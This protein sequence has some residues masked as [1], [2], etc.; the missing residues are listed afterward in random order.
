MALV[1]LQLGQCGNQVGQE[2]LELV[3]QDGRSDRSRSRADTYRAVSLERFFRQEA[4][5]NVPVARAVLVDMEPKVI[6]RTLSKAMKSGQWSYGNQSYF[7][8]KQ[9][10]GNNWANGF[11]IHGPQ[12]EEAVMDLV[13]REVEQCERLGGFIP[14]MSLAGGTGSGLGTYITRCL[15]DTYPN[16][17]ILNQLTWP[18]GTGEVI[19]QDYNAVLTL[20]HLYQSSDALLI[21]EN[22][23]LHKIC[24]QL[25]N[26]KQISFTDINKV[27]AHQLGS[28]LQPVCT[29]WSISEYG[30]NPLG[31]LLESL[32]THP[33]YKLLSLMNTPLM[34]DKSLQFST[35][36]WPALVKNLR[37]MLISNA[38]VEAGIDWQMKLPSAGHPPASKLISDREL[39][40]NT[41]L[42]NLLVLRGKE[43]LQ[44]DTDGFK[45]QALYTTWM[46]ADSALNIWRTCTTFNKYEKSATVVSNSQCLQKPLDSTVAKA[47][48]MFASRAYVHQY[49]KH[50]ISEED[51]LDCF[52][53]VEQII[54]SY[55]SLG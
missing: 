34:S 47:W 25:M 38:K 41:S 4:G 29:R 15:R 43:V 2:L 1:L 12:H 23:T 5:A 45:E 40:F 39:H 30:T 35:F 31:D 7:C 49:M 17:F 22:D 27:I 14:I 21:H 51:F 3:S 36:T 42:T 32:V 8:Q 52:T 13:R 10:S 9:G 20:S 55:S 54:A 18:Y 28:V 53:T 46:P 16:S 48:D 33:E 24:S 50:G 19:V 44:A 6:S 11:C 37:Q 26:I